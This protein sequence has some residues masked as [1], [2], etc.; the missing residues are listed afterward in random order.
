[1]LLQEKV[2][3]CTYREEMA[4]LVLVVESL[5]WVAIPQEKKRPV[6]V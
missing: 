3:Q 2:A 6:E 4:S 1:M 5:L